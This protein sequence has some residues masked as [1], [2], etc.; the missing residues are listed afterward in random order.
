MASPA[1]IAQCLTMLKAA[2]ATTTRGRELPDDTGE[3][4]ALLLQS[5]PGDVL[6]AATLKIIATETWFPTVAK[7]LEAA[8]DV[9]MAAQPAHDWERGWRL[10]MSAAEQI[11]CAIYTHV[12]KSEVALAEI[13]KHDQV[14]AETIKRLGWVEFCQHEFDAQTTWKAQFRDAYKIMVAREQQRI[15]IPAHVSAQ[16]MQVAQAMTASN[17]LA[18]PKPGATNGN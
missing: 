12:N 7:L 8:R 17:R 3:V 2:F 5:I 15:Q 6:Q 13:A 16:I 10:C 4:Y 1:E 11:G 18:A 14:A 9:Q